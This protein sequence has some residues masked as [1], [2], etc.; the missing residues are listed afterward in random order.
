MTTKNTKPRTI[1]KPSKVTKVTNSTNTKRV[2]TK[3]KPKEVKEVSTTKLT[4]FVKENRVPILASLGVVSGLSYLLM[5][6]KNE[7]GSPTFDDYVKLYN[8]HYNEYKVFDKE[9]KELNFAKPNRVVYDPKIKS[10]WMHVGIVR[11][12]IYFFDKYYNVFYDSDLVEII[13]DG[14]QLFFASYDDLV[15][16]YNIDDSFKY[17]SVFKESFERS[18]KARKRFQIIEVSLS[19]GV[20]NIPGHSNALVIDHKTKHV[21]LFEP[22]GEVASGR[23][24]E[25]SK[26]L[27]KAFKVFNT[28]GYSINEVGCSRSNG[29]QAYDNYCK[30]DLYSM[31]GHGYCSAWSVFYMELKLANPDTP[32]KQLVKKARRVLGTDHCRFIKAYAHYIDHFDY[33]VFWKK[34]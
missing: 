6:K 21:D 17:I 7:K 31:S 32:L 23:Y 30:D 12:F 28:I 24:S 15:G 22:H 5:R 8:Q 29:L 14:K 34:N 13:F 1:K 25:Y 27:F 20:Y 9:L 11:Y 33:T 18:I 3:P 19:S 10:T 26:K 2:S 4:K 16:E